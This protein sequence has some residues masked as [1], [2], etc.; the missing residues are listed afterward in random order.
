VR[1]ATLELRTAVTSGRAGA[2]TRMFIVALC[3]CRN[4]TTPFQALSRI[5]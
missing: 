1:L 5:V 4:A 3:D 2:E